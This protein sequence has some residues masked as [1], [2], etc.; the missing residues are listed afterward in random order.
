MHNSSNNRGN[1]TALQTTRPIKEGIPVH[2]LHYVRKE[3]SLDKTEG[4]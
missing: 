4:P 1:R 2:V 3:E